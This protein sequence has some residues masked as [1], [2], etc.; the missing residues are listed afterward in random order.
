MPRSHTKEFKLGLCRAIA[1]GETTKGRVCRENAL[2]GGLLD[3]WVRQHEALGDDAFSGTP[4]RE[5]L[6]TPEKQVA[7]L[8]KRLVKVELENEFLRWVVVQKKESALERGQD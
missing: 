1:A 8:K 6:A 5:K 3:R 2:S 7:D 4:W